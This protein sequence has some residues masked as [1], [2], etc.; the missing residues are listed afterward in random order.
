MQPGDDFRE[1]KNMRWRQLTESGMD[2]NQAY[3]QVVQEF[4][5]A[6]GRTRN[7]LAPSAMAPAPAARRPAIRSFAAESTAAPTKP[8]AKAAPSQYIRTALQ[9][10]TMGLSDEAE[11]AARSLLPGQTYESAIQDVRGKLKAFRQESPKAALATELAGG[12]ATGLA[13]GGKTLIGKAL[14][15][16]VVTGM[17]SGAGGAEGGVWE[18]A[19]GA[20]A[21]GVMGKVLGSI[22][23]PSRKLT[24]DVTQDI[25]GTMED[26]GAIRKTRALVDLRNKAATGLEKSQRFAADVL[27]NRGFGRAARAIEPVDE[28]TIRRTVTKN[29][30]GSGLTEGS[31]AQATEQAGLRA[32]Q[33][34]QQ[35]KAVGDEVQAVQVETVN[36]GK[37][38]AERAVEQAKARSEQLLSEARQK[39]S[40]VIGGVRQRAGTA[41]RVR[42]Q[43][44]NTQLAEAE[45]SYALV[46]QFGRPDR[47]P[48]A[49]YDAI[50]KSPG[51]RGAFEAAT[52]GRAEAGVTRR[53][54]AAEGEKL[55]RP[56]GAERLPKVTIQRRDGTVEQVPAL[57]LKTMDQMRQHV[58]ERI[59]AYLGGSKETGIAPQMGR[60]LLKQIGVLEDKFLSAYPDEARTAIQEARAGYR[61]KF[62]ALEALQDGLNLGGIKADKGAKLLSTNP[63]AFTALVEKMRT[64][65]NT[66]EA[67]EA[68]RAGGREWFNNLVTDRLDDALKFSQQMTKTEGGR[69][70]VALVFGKDMVEQMQQ[71]ARLADEAGG[72]VAKGQARAA[73]ITG[74]GE[75]AAEK[76]GDKLRSEV[77]G[78]QDLAG[79]VREQ[80]EGAAKTLAAARQAR[81]ALAPGGREAAAS[82]VD[83][84]LPQLGTE[85]RG[86]VQ[87]YGA[88]A[89]QREIAGLDAQTAL[90]RLEQLQGNPAARA[91]FGSQLDRTIEELQKRTLG[92]VARPAL[93]GLA[94][95]R[96]GGLFTGGNE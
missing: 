41:D 63:K 52:A 76:L 39:A 12:L 79:V 34:A 50:L 61:D 57:T 9:G 2:P 20:A 95:R 14:A 49:V 88:S 21:G 8:Q 25:A 74:M 56:L 65:Y 81:S 92:S 94:G 60:K 23:T 64:Q 67:R 75:Q 10:A 62:V 33:A 11:A 4:A 83:V 35:A 73:K 18:R 43:L 72:M 27:E 24:R 96:V 40:Q 91:L 87:D 3:D 58:N 19:K 89:I 53:L 16:P 38:L 31:L 93:A 45:Q 26:A 17:I 5:G 32:Q 48:I 70:R 80:A 42:D 22:L 55:F 37:A 1:Q 78:A 69:K 54:A 15:S 6:E 7:D 36:R 71:I 68:F 51:L 29:L 90:A 30:P 59:T 77:F 44:R 13:G 47:E 46:R 85:A 66:P 82:L 28:T 84:T 86:T